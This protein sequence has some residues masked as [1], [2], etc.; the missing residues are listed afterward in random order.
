ML[1]SMEC[2]FMGAV[3]RPGF[4]DPTQMQYVLGLAQGIGNLRLYIDAQQYARCLQIEPYS[5]VIVSLEFEP[6]AQ[7]VAYC[8]RLVDIN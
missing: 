6:T 5:D 7:K 8:M 3:A 4:K 1:M 2:K